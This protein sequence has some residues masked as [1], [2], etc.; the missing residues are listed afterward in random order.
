MNPLLL[1]RGDTLG[2]TIYNT[3]AAVALLGVLS[4]VG[5]GIVSGK[6]WKWKADRLEDRAELAEENAKT[7]QGN[8]HSADVGAANASQT[9]AT[10]D[11]GTFE[12]RLTTDAAAGRAES[13]DAINDDSSDSL[14][15]DLVRE[16]DAAKDRAGAA[17]NRLQ[18]KGRR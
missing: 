2:K 8:A 14:P 16:L 18:R 10:M 4:W 1:L 13:Y 12:I 7:A 5:W 15:A 9:R 11:G 17:A 6:Y 3:L